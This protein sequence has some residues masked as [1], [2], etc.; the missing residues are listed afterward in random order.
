MSPLRAVLRLLYISQDL[1]HEALRFLRLLVTPK[2]PLATEVLFL[3]KQLVF[4]QERKVKPPTP[5]ALRLFRLLRICKYCPSSANLQVVVG[6][7]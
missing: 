2:A 6:L 4:H 1:L 7:G 3:R 5:D